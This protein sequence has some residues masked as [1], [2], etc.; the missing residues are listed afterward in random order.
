MP[1]G[2]PVRSRHDTAAGRRGG[3]ARQPQPA[4]GRRL[5]RHRVRHAEPRPA[6]R[7]VGAVHQ[8]P[9]RLAALHAGPARPAGGRPR[10]PL[11]AVGLDRGV[12]GRHHHA[13]PPAGGHLHDAG[14][15]PPAPVRDGRRELPRRLRRLGVPARPRGRPVAHPAGPVL[16]RRAGAARPPAAVGARLRRQPHVVQ[17]GGRLPGP[18]DDG[19]GGRVARRRAVGDRASRRAGAAGRRRVRSRTSPSTRPSRGRVAT[20]PTGRASG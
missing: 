1:P 3:A 6:G 19:G 4:H 9:H 13:A 16:D 5:R 18:Q 7:P 8:P 11:A 20:T 12:G 2:P 17:G 10:L 15:G 14:V